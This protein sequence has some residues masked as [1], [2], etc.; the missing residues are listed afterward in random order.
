MPSANAL[1]R[2]WQNR[3][4]IPWMRSESPFPPITAALTEP[5]GLLAAGGEL[6]PPRLLEAYE[7]GIFPWYSE[8][9][10]ILWWSPDP[11]MVLF[12]DEFRM[13][14]SLRK[15]A[16]RRRFEIRVDSAFRSVL[17]ACADAPRPNQGGTWITPAVIA[18]YSAL[19]ARGYAHSVE[20]WRDRRL[21]G[22]LYGVAIGRMF[23]GESMFAK[24]TDASKVA[25]AALV[26]IMRRGGLPMIDCQQETT[27]LS[28]FGARPIPRREFAQ[29]LAPLVHSSAPDDTWRLVPD[30][31]QLAWQS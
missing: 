12:V 3:Q 14:R 20:A 28:S 11:R 18:A 8:G 21:V 5:N 13:S 25:L 9:Q 1:G 22:G 4:M 6:S 16:R 17:E 2:S 26:A 15:V 23:F 30:S 19:H 27:H 31:D 7:Q 29:R 24:E 10:P